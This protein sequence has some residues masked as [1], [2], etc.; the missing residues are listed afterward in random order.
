[1]H[2]KTLRNL[3]DRLD[4]DIV[5]FVSLVGLFALTV[6]GGLFLI[7]RSDASAEANVSDEPLG[8]CV[9][10]DITANG[11]CHQYLMWEDGYRGGMT[12]LPN[13][14]YCPKDVDNGK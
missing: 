6:V 14:K 13:C 11:E 4:G 8:T 1:M 2:V 5:Y 9:V 12:H 10:T 3:I 7:A